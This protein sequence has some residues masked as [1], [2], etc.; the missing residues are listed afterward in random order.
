MAIVPV[1]E[2]QGDSEATPVLL[3]RLLGDSGRWDIQVLRSK[4]ANGKSKLLRKFESFLRY[5]VIEADCEAILVLLDADEDCAAELARGLAARAEQLRLRV[6]VAVVVA[7]HEYEGWF[8]AA[9]D[10]NPANPVRARLNLN[11]PAAGPDAVDKVIRNPKAW[12]EERMPSDL[13]Y[14]ETEDQVWLSSQIDT[15]LVAFRSRSFQRLQHA[16]TE[17]TLA[18]DLGQSSV[19]PPP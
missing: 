9:L 19:T 13:A 4:C 18:I 14:K 7:D 1:V 10:A 2:G 5:A 16:V 6:P 15:R 17:L 11:E 8:I 12:L 3:R